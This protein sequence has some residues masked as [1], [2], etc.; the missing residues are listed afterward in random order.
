M[1]KPYE[2]EKNIFRFFYN[3]HNRTTILFPYKFK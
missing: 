3:Q 2:V 1:N